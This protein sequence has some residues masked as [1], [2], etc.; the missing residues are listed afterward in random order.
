MNPSPISTEAAALKARYGALLA[1]LP[2][3]D[4][5]GTRE[6]ISAL[7]AARARLQG[8]ERA[9]AAQLVLDVTARP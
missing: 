3:C 2:P 4:G 1:P 5:H 9:C 7:D 6:A 8:G